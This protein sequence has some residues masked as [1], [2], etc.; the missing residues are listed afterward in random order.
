MTMDELR[1]RLI[2]AQVAMEKW[3]DNDI[4]FAMNTLDVTRHMMRKEIDARDARSVDEILK[5]GDA[6]VK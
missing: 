2:E 1:A 6:H 5:H 3:S 4:W